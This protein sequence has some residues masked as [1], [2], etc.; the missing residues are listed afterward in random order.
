VQCIPCMSV[1]VHVHLE[2]GQCSLIARFSNGAA[3]GDLTW[4]RSRARTRR[5]TG[6]K[7]GEPSSPLVLPGPLDSL[8]D[9]CCRL[10]TAVQ[11]MLVLKRKPLTWK[12]EIRFREACV[13]IAYG[14]YLVNHTH[15]AIPSPSSRRRSD[16]AAEYKPGSSADPRPNR[17]GRRRLEI[18]MAL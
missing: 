15:H 16:A 5:H 2:A 12:A 10:Q 7:P 8:F 4:T 14:P 18:T 11:K 6:G 3:K 9:R 17:N 13:F 1:H